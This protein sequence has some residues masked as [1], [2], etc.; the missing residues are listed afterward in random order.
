M[1]GDC[2]AHSHVKIHLLNGWEETP[3][4]TSAKLF[5]VEGWNFIQSYMS[6]LCFFSFSYIIQHSHK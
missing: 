2:L 5:E 3:S 4:D 6:D 1:D